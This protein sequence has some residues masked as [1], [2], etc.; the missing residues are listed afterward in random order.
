MEPE[1]EVRAPGDLRVE[2]FL[3]RVEMDLEPHEK[4]AD[5][6]VTSKKPDEAIGLN[7]ET[8]NWNFT[9]PD[10][11]EFW[12]VIRGSGP[13]NAHRVAL[14]RFSYEQGAWVRRAIGTGAVAT[15][16]AA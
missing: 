12:R 4:D 11:D 10:W 13:C 14:R 16:P 8:G 5:G 9:E 6:I 15:P 7:E 2:P 1:V 3:P